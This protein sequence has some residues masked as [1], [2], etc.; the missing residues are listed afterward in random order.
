[1]IARLRGQVW[2]KLPPNIVVIDANGV[3]YEVE[4]PISTFSML[5][6]VKSEASLYIQQIVREDANL[7]YGFYTLEEK[8][9][10]RIFD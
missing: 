3:G 8:E 2:E 4:V 6:A 10:F 1:M 9:A 7:L 5:P